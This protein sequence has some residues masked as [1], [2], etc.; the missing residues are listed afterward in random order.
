[1]VADAAKTKIARMC[2]R[3]STT[4]RFSWAEIHRALSTYG[5]VKTAPLNL[6]PNDDV[7]PTTR[8]VTARLD[9]DG[10][11][12]VEAKRWGL[13][14]FWRGGKPV[15]DSQ[16]GK[17][18]G[19]KLTTFNA[20]VETV[21]TAATFRE[22]FKRRRCIVPASSWFEW[23]GEKGSKVKHRFTR[24][25]HGLI[26]FAGIHDTVQTT[27]E[28]QVDSFTILTG[29]SEGWLADYHDRAPV[30]LD[31]ADWATWLDP[32]KDATGLFEAV[33]PERFILA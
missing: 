7:R 18:D 19:F 24:A 27:D 16:Q 11:W 13:I 32:T 28:G 5:E 26:W 33:R 20:R 9:D 3:Y 23:T 14:P 31:E 8:Q 22:S 25:D 30:I 4:G 10:G 15:K 21:S 17:G 29:P 1:V 2:G 6:E 12:I